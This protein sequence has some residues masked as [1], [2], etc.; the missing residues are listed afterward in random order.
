[1][2]DRWEVGVDK[3]SSASLIDAI[4]VL[5]DLST[6]SMTSNY[7]CATFW[8][9]FSYPVLAAESIKRFVSFAKIEK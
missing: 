5:S 1:M 9:D 6:Y 7:Y 8:A 2:Y 4:I 3:K